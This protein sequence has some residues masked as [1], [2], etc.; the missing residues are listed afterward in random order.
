VIT[1]L[2]AY[3]S[4]V[5]GELTAKRLALQRSESFAF[6]L[7]P[8]VDLTASLTRPVIWL[9]AVSTNAV[10]RVLGGDPSAAREEITDE[11]IRAVVSGSSTLGEEERQIVE[12]VFDAG[13]R[14]L[15]EVIVP[16]T[17]VDFPS[18]PKSTQP[19]ITPTTKRRKRRSFTLS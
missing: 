19:H 6:A 1:G 9:L 3:V 17:E 5:V 8:L 14:T 4:I 2:I 10:V 7:A 11:E 12:D 13:A 18:A 15:R 16:R